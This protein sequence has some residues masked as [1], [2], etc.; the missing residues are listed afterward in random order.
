[1]R[2]DL[3][4]GW[5]SGSGFSPELNRD[6]IALAATLS[7]VGAPQD[8]AL[9]NLQARFNVGEAVQL[10]KKEKPSYY[11]LGAMDILLQM[12][13]QQAMLPQFPQLQ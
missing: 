10:M 4:P 5:Y 3:P 2:M 12:L 13:M 9:Q 1:M 6:K 7:A 11:E 8:I